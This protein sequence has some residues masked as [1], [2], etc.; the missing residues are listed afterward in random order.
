M[1]NAQRFTCDL[2]RFLASLTEKTRIAYRTD[3]RAFRRAVLDEVATA[4]SRRDIETYLCGLASESGADRACSA[5]KAFY[6]WRCAVGRAKTNP[7]D[8]IFPRHIHAQRARPASL[9]RGAGM[10]DEVIERLS[11]G[12]VVA[13]LLSNPR[14]RSIRVKRKLRALPR[15]VHEALV[16]RCELELR[17]GPLVEVLTR[18]IVSP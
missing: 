11:W 13:P 16:Q 2:G 18:P 17:R 7:A 15:S 10:S 1:T 4:P 9:L 12:D 5:I 3:M 8:P 14:T 6:R